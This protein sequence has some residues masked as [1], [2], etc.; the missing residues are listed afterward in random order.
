M[1]QVFGTEADANTCS[2]AVL[3]A[4][5]SLDAG[6][7]NAIEVTRDLNGAV[8]S[9]AQTIFVTGTD[10][11]VAIPG[12][13]TGVTNDPAQDG[14]STERHYWVVEIKPPAGFINPATVN[15]VL[16]TTGT[17][18]DGVLLDV[19]NTQHN[20]SELPKTGA[21]VGSILAIGGVALLVGMIA[22]AATRSRK[23]ATK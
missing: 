6:C 18:A 20:P 23:A 15:D 12:L 16:V 3:A 21:V 10:G 2:A 9:P 22:V 13:S 1:F 8:V 17:V 11:K 14:D 4:D 7:A 19:P 5:G